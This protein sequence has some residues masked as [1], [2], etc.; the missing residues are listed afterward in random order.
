MVVSMQSLITTMH[1]QAR[2]RPEAVGEV[3]DELSREVHTHPELAFEEHHAV[4]VVATVL[5]DAGFGTAVGC[6]G[7]PTAVPKPASA[8]TVATT[9]TAWCS[10]NASSGWVCTSRESSSRTSPTASGRA[11][12]CS[13]IVVIR[14]CIDTTIS[15]LRAR[16]HQWIRSQQ[17]PVAHRWTARSL[18]RPHRDSAGRSPPLEAREDTTRAAGQDPEGLRDLGRQEDSVEAVRE[19]ADLEQGLSADPRTCGHDR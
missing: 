13:C 11:R 18:A 10:S 5:A 3:L 2:A 7:L 8:R 9:R 17:D 1:E 19:L 6:Y 15:P 12:A 14:L 4:R 16:C